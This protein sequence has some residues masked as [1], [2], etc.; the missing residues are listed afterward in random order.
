[1]LRYWTGKYAF[2]NVSALVFHFRGHQSYN[3]WTS[4]TVDNE[5]WAYGV[6]F[7]LNRCEKSERSNRVQ[8]L[9]V[10]LQPGFKWTAGQIPR[11]LP[12][13]SSIS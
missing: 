5:V 13:R 4:Y 7:V 1:M 3:G 11:F 6:V 8:E 12:V 10:Y 9:F 2:I